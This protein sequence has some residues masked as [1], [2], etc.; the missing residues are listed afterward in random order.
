[1]V[2]WYELGTQENLATDIKPIWCILEKW[3]RM[4][5]AL[6]KIWLS[7]FLEKQLRTWIAYSG[8]FDTKYIVNHFKL[9][10]T[11]F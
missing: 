8:K 3:P 9:L 4:K 6:W 2:L 7:F 1:M 11:I 5:P 10:L